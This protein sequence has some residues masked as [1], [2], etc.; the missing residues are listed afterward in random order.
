MTTPSFHLS[1][2]KSL[3][4]THMNTYPANEL[5]KEHDLIALSRVF[6]PASRGQL[7]IVKNLLT[8]HRANFR[9]YENGMVSFDIDALVR[10]ASLKGSYKTGERII[11]L[12]SAGLNLQ[13]LA[14]TPL[15]IPMV[16]KEPI[17]IRL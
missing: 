8:D 11:E 12:V 10:E 1:L 17:S 6:P 7:I 2:K 15:R 9:S 16:G 3:R 5:L 4:R 13:A 14:K